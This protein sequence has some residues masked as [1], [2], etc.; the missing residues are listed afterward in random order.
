LSWGEVLGVSEYRLY[1]RSKGEQTFQLLYAGRDRALTDKRPGIV[2]AYAVPGQAGDGG[3]QVIMEYCVASFNGN[4]EGKRSPLADSDPASW[5]NWDPMPGEP[6][7]R[8][9]S[10]AADTPESASEWPRYYPA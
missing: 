10:F 4:G 3:P 9:E 7:R 1:A 5:R 2:A 6:F 8:V